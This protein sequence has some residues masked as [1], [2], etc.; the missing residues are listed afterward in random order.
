MDGGIQVLGSLGGWGSGGAVG[1]EVHAFYKVVAIAEWWCI[2]Q[3]SVL[4]QFLFYCYWVCFS[5]IRN[6]GVIMRMDVSNK[7]QHLQCEYQQLQ[8]QTQML[9]SRVN[10][11]QCEVDTLG[12]Y[13]NVNPGD[14]AAMAN[15]RKISR[16]LQT[17][18]NQVRNNTNKLATLQMRMNT[19]SQR[20][21]MQQQRHAVAMGNRMLK[22]QNSQMRTQANMVRKA[23]MG[24]YR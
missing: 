7:L 6:G 3:F 18:L 15:Y 22:A 12:R 1:A 14:R 24:S 10:P 5:S 2:W 17:L 13:C 8:A 23:M 4:G 20:I 21:V 19:E 16:N 9:Q 11:L